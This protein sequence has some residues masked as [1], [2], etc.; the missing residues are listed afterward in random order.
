MADG[1]WQGTCKS[2]RQGI[3]RK[4]KKKKRKKRKRHLADRIKMNNKAFFFFFQIHQN[5]EARE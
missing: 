1:L 2:T 3:K 4:G 5:Q